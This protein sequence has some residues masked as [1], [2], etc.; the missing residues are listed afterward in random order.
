MAKIA[1]DKYYTEDNLAKYCVEK[2]FEILG[3][4]WDRII[5]AAA[6]IFEISSG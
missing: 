1:L 6:G 4:D 2:T 5:E 3:S